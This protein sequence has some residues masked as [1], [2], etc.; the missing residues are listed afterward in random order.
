[1]SE[2]LDIT[3]H[4]VTSIVPSRGDI[5]FTHPIFVQCFLPLR[6]PRNTKLYTAKNGRASLAIQAGVLLNPKTGDFI[7]QE[8]PYGSA[9]RIIL[10]HIH[11]HINR[12]ASIDEAQEIPMGESIR[13]FFKRYNLKIGGANGKQT[14]KNS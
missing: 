7:E 6:R 14:I 4:N 11:N 3:A 10:A 5:A 1:M 13:Q 2:L 12:S 9:A 8:V